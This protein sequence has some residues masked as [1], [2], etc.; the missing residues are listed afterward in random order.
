VIPT[1]ITAELDGRLL[2]GFTPDDMLAELR[3][4]IGDEVEVEIT[5]FNPGPP[6]DMGLYNTLADILRQADPQGIPIPIINPDVTD[7]AYFSRLGIQTYGF[8][9][10]NMPPDFDWW[11]TIHNADERIPVAALEFG[12]NAVYQVLQ[13]F[14]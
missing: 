1:A 11:A 9:P 10:M 2:P 14:G 4:I 3:P 12:T 5:Q 13:R 7:A 6:P 8:L